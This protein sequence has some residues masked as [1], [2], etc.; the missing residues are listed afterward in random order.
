M[1]LSSME[2]LYFLTGLPF[3][4]MALPVDPQLPGDERL[5]YLEHCHYLGPSPMSG[6]VICIKVIDD[7]F[8]Q[9]ITAMVVRIYGSLET[10]RIIRGQ[11][12]IVERVPFF[13]GVDVALQD[14]G[15]DS[16]VLDLQIW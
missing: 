5:V 16:Q 14:D 13:L 10:Q 9:C 11:L 12:R 4:G 3:W 8:T 1:K 2:D 6:L 15:E 7:L